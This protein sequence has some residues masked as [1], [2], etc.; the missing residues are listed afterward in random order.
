M[1]IVVGIVLRQV[2]PVLFTYAPNPRQMPF[3]SCASLACV[4]PVVTTAV[5]AC[6]G[7]VTHVVWDLFTHDD[8]WGPQHIGGLRSEAVSLVGHSIT[9]AKLL[10]FA[11]HA[12]GSIVAL[13]LLARILR[14][15]ALLRWYGVRNA[16]GPVGHRAGSTR[17]VAVTVIGTAAGGV[18]AAMGH[19]V[20]AKINP[21]QHRLG[22]WTD[23]HSL[24]CRR[25]VATG[26]RVDNAG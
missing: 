19:G 22:G 26:V 13:R 9:W 14:S 11:S 23:R 20:P 6:L 21:R 12:L 17:F 24:V 3:N 15:G 18:W 1:A 4:D 25:A 5:S 10:Q 7:A 8:R 2:A 16:P